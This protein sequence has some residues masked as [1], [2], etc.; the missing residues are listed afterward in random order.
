MADR[1]LTTEGGGGATLLPRPR[2]PQSHQNKK[3]PAAMRGLFCLPLQRESYRPLPR[4]R[5]GFGAV[6]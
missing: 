2:P 5:L 6:G 4:A 3:G 1:L